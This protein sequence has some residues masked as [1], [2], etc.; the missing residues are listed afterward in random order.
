VPVTTPA[1]GVIEAKPT[2]NN[3][4]FPVPVHSRVAPFPSIVILLKII[5]VAVG[6]KGL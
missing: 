5:G 2:A 6:P 4:E 3:R 1:V